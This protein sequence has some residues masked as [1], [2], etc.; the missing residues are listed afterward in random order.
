MT[1]RY[2]SRSIG[3]IFA[4]LAASSVRAELPTALRD[5]GFDQ[6][7]DAPLPLDAAIRDEAGRE[8]KLGDY[9]TSRPVILVMTQFRCPMLCSEVL[10]G[11]VRAL[12]D[13]PLSPSSDFDIL[14]ISFDPRETPDMAA[15]KKRTYVER[16][17]RPEAE[18]G[19][20]FLT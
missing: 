10:N 5:V 1:Q 11:L 19:W 12:L 2:R 14:A 16:Y 18:R 17:G 7:L 6:R 8:V 3:V 9:F 4:L 15:A 20:H 13:V